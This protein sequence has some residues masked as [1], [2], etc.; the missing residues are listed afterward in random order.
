MNQNYRNNEMEIYESNS[1]QARLPM[2]SNS[3]QISN[4]SDMSNM[5]YEEWQDMCGTKKEGELFAYATGTQAA[6]DITWAILHIGNPAFSEAGGI[7]RTI[8]PI[9]WPV[10]TQGSQAVWSSFMDRGEY[11]LEKPI[12]PV[13]KSQVLAEITG[14]ENLLYQYQNI[15]QV[16]KENPGDA[17]VKEGVRAIFTYINNLFFETI[18]KFSTGGEAPKYKV[19]LLPVYAEF[20]N[21]HLLLLRDAA[22]FGKSWGMSDA[23]ITTQQNSLKTQTKIYTDYCVQTYNAGLSN[24]PAPNLNDCARYPWIRYDRPDTTGAIP[25]N[26]CTGREITCDE[27]TN[28][29]MTEASPRSLYRSAREEYIGTET[30]NLYNDF[31]REMTIMVLDLIALWPTYDPTKYNIAVKQELTRELYTPIRGTTYQNDASQ[32]TISAIENRMTRRPHLFEWLVDADQFVRSMDASWIKGEFLCG[33]KQKIKFTSLQHEKVY[34]QGDTGSNRGFY[35]LNIVPNQTDITALRT[36]N[37]FEMRSWSYYQNGSWLTP[38]HVVI[39]ETEPWTPTG[40]RPYTYDPSRATHQISRHRLAFWMWQP[41]RNSAPYTRWNEQQLSAVTW[42]W[43]HNSVDPNNDLAI[44]KITQL[45]AVKAGDSL[46]GG[47]TVIKGPGSTGG[48]VVQ[49]PATNDIQIRLLVNPPQGKAYKIRIRYAS[50]GNAELFIGRYSDGG[51]RDRFS[52]NLTSTYSGE[53]TYSAFQYLDAFTFTR[54]TNALPSI[55]FNNRGGGGTVIIDKIEFIPI[56]GSLEEYEAN[57]KLEKARKVVNALFSDT[58]KQRL[59][60]NLMGIDLDIAMGLVEEIPDDRFPKEKMILRDQ[61][62]QAKRMS[63][64]RNLLQS[65]DFSSPDWS[66]ENG[67]IISNSVSVEAKNPIL[68]G[69][70]LNLP[71]ARDPLSDGNVYPSYAYQKVDESKLKP[72]TRYWIRGLIGNSKDLELIVSRYRKEVH[73]TLHVPDNLNLTS[74]RSHL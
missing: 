47:A 58:V 51:W 26:A 12:N 28:E 22:K 48:D 3:T 21:L 38:A 53:L 59:R 18:P 43:T 69:K 66:G 15:L 67:W 55:E 50:T 29:I 23:D 72:Y 24:T 57:Q 4:T 64:S 19:Q 16:L 56:T 34:Y 71:S 73:K 10:E 40:P 36:S 31:R 42:A 70:Y 65:G 25:P 5:G 54:T 7:Y 1:V 44:D 62:K 39:G 30:W 41:V 13:L 61:I 45:R 68:H 74:L 6:N 8:A 11:L 20:T 27:Q 60:D 17:G 32:N 2:Q 49:L 33:T 35:Y 37:W 9:L 46:T 52:Y 14:F 63:Q